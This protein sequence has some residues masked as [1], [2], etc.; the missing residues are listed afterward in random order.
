MLS[1]TLAFNKTQ[2][3]RAE[4]GGHTEGGGRAVKGLKKIGGGLATGCWGPRFPL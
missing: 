3:K 1:E 2:G 4:G